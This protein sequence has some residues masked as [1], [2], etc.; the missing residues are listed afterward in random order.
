[1]IENNEKVRVH[2]TGRLSMIL[3]TREFSGILSAEVRHKMAESG[4]FSTLCPEVLS[5]YVD[6]NGTGSI[7]GEDLGR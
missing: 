6:S 4:H 1:M 7:I 3:P 2:K 5:F